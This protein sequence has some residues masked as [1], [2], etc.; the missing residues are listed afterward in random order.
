MPRRL[1][2]LVTRAR[3]RAF[4]AL[5]LLSVTATACGDAGDLRGAGPT[6]TAAGPARLWPELPPASSPAFDIGEVDIQVVKGVGVPGDDIREVDPVAV[7][8]AEIARSPGDYEGPKARYRG[9]N[10]R[11]EECGRAGD[12]AGCP[13][14]EPYYRDL[15]G[16]G[17]PEMTLGFRL[18]PGEMTAVRVYTVE[19]HRLVQVMAYDDAVS[20]IEIAGQSVILRAPSEVPGYQ[21]RLQWSWDTDQR[22]MLLTHDEM[23]RT[24]ERPDPEY[25][26]RTPSRT[27]SASPR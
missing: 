7:V 9:T 25:P 10:S 16:D 20:S 23:L 12:G 17:R 8:R 19:R 11:M 22:A 1:L 27:P 18:L 21:Y 4:T 13:V 15:T 3:V 14:L 26:P 24:G 5:A 2:P 6:P